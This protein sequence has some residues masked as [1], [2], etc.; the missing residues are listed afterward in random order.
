MNMIGHHAIGVDDDSESLS[1]SPKPFQVRLVIS[2]IEKYLSSLIAS[3]D[4]MIENAA[5]E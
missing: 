3:D 5:G 2:V 4:H 1:I